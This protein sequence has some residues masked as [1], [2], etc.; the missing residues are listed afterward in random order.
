[1]FG[2]RKANF[3]EIRENIKNNF[4]CNVIKVFGS[5]DPTLEL[6]VPGLAQAEFAAIQAAAAAEAAGFQSALAAKQSFFASL[7]GG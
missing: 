6:L 2:K 5:P 1:M 4:H 7:F 3:Y